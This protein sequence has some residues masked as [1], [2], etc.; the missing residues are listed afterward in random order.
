[1]RRNGTGRIHA[2]AAGCPLACRLRRECGPVPRNAGSARGVPVS[3]HRTSKPEMWKDRIKADFHLATVI[4]FGA[5]TVL[6]ITPFAVYRFLASQPVAGTI[7]LLI[8]ACISAGAV[9]AW[10]TGRTT[11]AATFLAVSYSIGC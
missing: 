1:T 8:V 2:C 4:M 3:C 9:H 10:R 5:I 6:G 11:G 7:D